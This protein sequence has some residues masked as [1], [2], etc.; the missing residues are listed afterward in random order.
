MDRQQIID[1]LAQILIQDI[2]REF[3]E[4]SAADLNRAYKRLTGRDTF[5]AEL[6]RL[7]IEPAEKKTTVHTFGGVPIRRRRFQH[8][9]LEPYQTIRPY[10]SVEQA[11][12]CAEIYAGAPAGELDEEAI[13]GMFGADMF[14]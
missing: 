9:S 14:A 12:T 11:A 6:S 10:L 1:F 5:Y 13:N 7:G 8:S 3:N 4:L 2:D